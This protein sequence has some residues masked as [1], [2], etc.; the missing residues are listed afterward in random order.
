MEN[1]LTQNETFLFISMKSCFVSIHVVV[2]HTHDYRDF[3]AD[4]D[5]AIFILIA[6]R[7][8]KR[9]SYVVCAHEQ[10]VQ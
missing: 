8:E 2:W 4:N 7:P 6:S 1:T 10:V 9:A 3:V 5:Y